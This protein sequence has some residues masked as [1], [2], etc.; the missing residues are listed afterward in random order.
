VSQ[1]ARVVVEVQAGVMP[2][3]PEP[4]FTRSWAITTDEWEEA[5][6]RDAASDDAHAYYAEL[7]LMA[8]AAAADEYARL[9]RD[10]ARFNW[11]RTEWLWL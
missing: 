8:R 3:E 4:H 7:L 10:P 1:S 2:G 5:Q 6:A 9:L 11:V